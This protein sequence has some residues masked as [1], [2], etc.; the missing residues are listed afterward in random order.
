MDAKDTLVMSSTT[1]APEQSDM[2]LETER[3]AD[4]APLCAFSG[5]PMRGRR[6]QARFC[7]DAGRARGRRLG[8]QLWC[9]P[10]GSQGLGGSR[11]PKTLGTSFNNYDNVLFIAIRR[12]KRLSAR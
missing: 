3:T 1:D 2:A 9:H 6:P 10:R 7:S 5:T 8:Q 4:N 11:D 12:P